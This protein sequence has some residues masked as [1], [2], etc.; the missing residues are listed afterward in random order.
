[1]GPFYDYVIQPSDRCNNLIEAI[2][3]I[4]DLNEKFSKIWFENKNMKNTK[5][6]IN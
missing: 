1:M 2:N 3:L 5:Q 6:Q 4:L